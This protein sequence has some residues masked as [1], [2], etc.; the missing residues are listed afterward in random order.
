MKPNRLVAIAGGI[1]SGKSTV[2]RILIALGAYVIDTDEINS[3]LLKDMYYIKKVAEAFPSV[4]INGEINK[5]K[6]SDIVLSD[7]NE[8][9]KLNKM[10][11][12]LIM[13]LVIEEAKNSNKDIVFVEIPLLIAS[14]M[15]SV[16]D[17]IWYIKCEYNYRIERVMKR[18]NLSIERVLQL[19]EI[20][21]N[22]VKALDIADTVIVNDMDEKHLWTQVENNY[23]ELKHI[24]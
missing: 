1:G 12:S 18:D 11:H 10:A 22:E 3:S 9:A 24:I 20:Q 17:Y 6:L 5:K 4:Y 2:S 16:F 19:M 14:N 21:K 7:N 13:A 8:M 23:N 15:E